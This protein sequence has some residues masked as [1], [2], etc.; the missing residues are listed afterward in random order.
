M[1]LGTTFR[2]YAIGYRLELFKKDR[3]KKVK[4]KA[5]G[6]PVIEAYMRYEPL[7]VK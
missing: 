5:I 1:V 6:R 7:P 4:S 3:A 2:R